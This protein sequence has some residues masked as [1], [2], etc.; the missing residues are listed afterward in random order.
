[1]QKILRLLFITLAI[2]FVRCT[3]EHK[4]SYQLSVENLETGVTVNL[5]GLSVVNDSVVWASGMQGIFL[6]TNDGGKNWYRDTVAGAESL[7]FRS[8]WAFGSDTALLVSAG[9]PA[10]I[11]KTADGGVHWKVVYSSDNPA[12]FLDAIGFWDHHRGMVM[13]DPFD[14]YLFLLHTED[15]GETWKRLPVANIPQSLVAEGGFA[16]SGTCLETLPPGFAWI[17]TG[18]DSARVY[19]SQDRGK[20]W[21]VTNTPV[22]SGGQMRGIFSLSFKDAMH[23]IAVGGEWNAANPHQS[24]AYTQNGGATWE[25]ATGAGNYCSGS[26]YVRDEVFLACG[27]SGIDISTD[28]GKTWKRIGSSHLYGLA[29]ARRGLTGYG[30]GPDGKIFKLR[31]KESDSESRD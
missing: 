7:D 1:M 20:H 4:K 8:V 27:Q 12:V 2:L 23:G 5:R 13:G 31:L 16:A 15:G 21:K 10:R 17:G 28:L 29:F 25:P 22:Y 11:Y 26:C 9:T 18:G 24:K 30:T 3:G 14:G 6:M 19:R